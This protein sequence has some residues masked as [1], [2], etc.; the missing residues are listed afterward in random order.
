MPYAR[1]HHPTTPPSVPPSTPPSVPPSV[2]PTTPP[3]T[4]P[5]DRVPPIAGGSGGG[6]PRFVIIG[7][8]ALVVSGI[9]IGA[10]LAF[11]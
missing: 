8:V 6:V 5:T 7:L 4:P 1:P 2:Y 9:A 11:Q 10:F 3:S